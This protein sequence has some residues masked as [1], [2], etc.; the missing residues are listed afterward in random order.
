MNL[1]K[2]IQAYWIHIIDFPLFLISY[3][4]CG[5]G[6]LKPFFYFFLLL[7]DTSQLF[8]RKEPAL[9]GEGVVKS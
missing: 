3:V 6:M 9:N 4:Y 1:L 7:F 2:K 8:R 5:P